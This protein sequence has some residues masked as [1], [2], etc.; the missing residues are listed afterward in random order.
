M[1]SE[2][3]ASKEKKTPI[4]WDFFDIVEV[5]ILCTAA[6]VLFFSFF[7]RITIVDGSSMEQTLHHGEFLAVSDLFYTPERGD[8]VVVHDTSKDG[9][10]GTPIVKRVIATEGET[11]DID[12]STW[13]V[14]VDG[15]VIDESEYIYLA[16]DQVLTSAISFPLTLKE[17][18]VFVMGDNRYHSGDSRI[19][20]PVH[21]E[22]IVGKAFFRLFPFNKIGTLSLGNEN[23]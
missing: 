9:I 4:S 10:Y 6:I 22:C 11:I 19:I 12:F 7:A 21:E 13:T 2:I 3:Q 14:T 15:E 16:S 23:K 1:N 17:D 18:E 5:F 8:I 20:G